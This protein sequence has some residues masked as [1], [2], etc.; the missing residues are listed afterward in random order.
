LSVED[1]ALLAEKLIGPS[2]RE[3]HRHQPLDQL[4]GRARRHDTL[5]R[6]HR[7]HAERQ[8]QMPP[9]ELLNGDRHQQAVREVYQAIVVIAAPTQ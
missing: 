9:F 1:V 2:R 3:G 4:V 5:N 6:Q 8:P 7:R